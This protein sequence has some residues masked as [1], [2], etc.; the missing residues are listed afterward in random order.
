MPADVPNLI[1]DFCHAFGLELDP[2]PLR[3][4]VDDDRQVGLACQ[5]TKMRDELLHRPFSKAN[6]L[7][8]FIVLLPTELHPAGTTD[9]TYRPLRLHPAGL[10]DVTCQS[11]LRLHPAVLLMRPIGQ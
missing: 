9:M 2:R 8:I 4:V 6:Y 7:N 11:L 1:H 3:D 10:T 5:C